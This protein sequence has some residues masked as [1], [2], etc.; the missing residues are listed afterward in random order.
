MLG[1][2]GEAPD[3]RLELAHDVGHASEVVERL[4]QARCRLVALHLQAFDSG[5]LLEQLPALL[6]TQGERR[7]DRSLPHHDELVGAEASLAQQVDHVPQARA[8][9]VDE[10]LAVAGSVRPS[11]DRDL[12]EVDRQPAVVVVERQDRLGHAEG[13]ALLRP[14]EDHVVRA[15]RAQR[16]VRL[17]PEHPAHR[18]G[19]VALSRAVRADDGVDAGLEH[20]ARRV[21]EGLEA[22]ESELLQ[23]AHAGSALRGASGSSSARAAAAARSSAR[24]R[25]EPIPEPARRPSRRTSTRNSWSWGGPSV[26]TR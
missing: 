18:I 5:S 22:V 11:A 23:A 16:S 25:L 7:V 6:G 4:H 3:L 15:S 13:L 24:C 14:G 9:A 2:K 8:R 12:G 19:H 21:G 10:V 1:L 20:E 17:L 26:E